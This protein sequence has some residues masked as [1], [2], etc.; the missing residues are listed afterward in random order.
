MMAQIACLN[1]GRPY[2]ESGL[3]HVCPDC[4]G[5]FDFVDL[6]AFE[7]VEGSVSGLWRFAPTFGLPA[8]TPQLSLG[9]GGTPLV[10]SEAFGRSVAFKC[11][12]LNPSGSFKDRGSAVLVSALAGRGVQAAVED[13]S[14]NAGASFAAYAARAVVKARVFVPGSASGPKLQQIEAYGA[15][16]V[17]VPGE[18]V[19]ATGAAL[20]AVQQGAAYASHAYLPFNLPGYATLAYEL[21]E[22]FGEA[23]G[24]VVIPAGQGGLLLGVGRGFQSLRRSGLIERLPL[25]IGV[26]AAACAPLWAEINGQPWNGSQPTLAEG[27]AVSQPLRAEAVLAVVKESGGRFVAV[28]ESFIIPGRDELARRG[29]YVELTSALVWRAL[30]ETLPGLTDPVVAVLTG[31]GLKSSLL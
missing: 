7:T 28:D 24:A 6:P 11:E 1:C 10:W 22:T 29:L 8:E 17:P 27:V 12:Y 25:L 2:P 26:Q 30:Q 23:P 15:Q 19:R 21:Y 20:E 5:L 3:P 16:V 18:R 9:E 4:G 14:G 13:S 31:S